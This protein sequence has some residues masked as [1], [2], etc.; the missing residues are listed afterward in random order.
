M[1]AADVG[2]PGA[3]IE[4][5][6]VEG[7]GS[8]VLAVVFSQVR[9]PAG[10]FGLSRLF[11]RTRHACLFV[12]QP[13]GRWYRGADEAIDDAVA[14]AG[15]QAR[16]DRVVFYGSS[17][18]GWGALAAAARHPAARVIAFAPDARVGE[19]GS[20]SADAGL[21]PDGSEPLLAD[22][23]AGTG[24][25]ATVVSGLF[26]PY[27]AGVFARMSEARRVGAVL[28]P[29]RSVHAVHDHLYTVN[30][31]RRIIGGFDRDVADAV[32]ARGLLHPPVDP[33]E[34]SR[35]AALALAVE[36]GD[37]VDPAAVRSLDLAGNPGVGLL[38]ADVLARAGDLVGADAR[39]RLLVVDISASPVLSTLPKRWL[40]GLWVRRVDLARRLGR[41]DAAERLV[42][43]A[44]RLF[45]S[46]GRFAP[47]R[48]RG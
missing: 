27:D 21:S 40:K 26:D 38:E 12:N 47:A 32:A 42:E 39:L 5:R 19:P 16:P 45:P 9:V 37:A 28:V 29:V 24:A 25:R 11:A 17:M 4:T 3:R 43:E 15:E 13:S 41:A 2:S 6:F 23:L 10:H 22:L 48:P 44:G 35:F 30:V 34:L 1:T 36:A 33:A 31:I 7:R 18:G 20:R 46:D 14:A 8:G